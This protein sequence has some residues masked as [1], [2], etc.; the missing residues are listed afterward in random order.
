MSLN[1][2][3]LNLS[4]KIIKD[5]LGLVSAPNV[6]YT[7]KT[8]IYHLINTCTSQNSVNQVSNNCV[9]GH[10]EGTIRY[11]LRN[12]DLEEVQQALNHKLKNNAFKTVE[13][14]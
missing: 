9:D 3:V 10:S 4:V 13:N 1:G 12:L 2:D 7:D 14:L 6:K 11:R 5:M 8:I